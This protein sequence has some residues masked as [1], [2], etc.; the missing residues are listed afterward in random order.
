[1]TGLTAGILS[2][3]TAHADTLENIH[4]TGV[5]RIAVPQD[6]APFGSASSDMSLQGYDVEVAKLTAAALHVKLQLVPVTMAN[7]IPYLVTNKVDLALNLG[8]NPERAK[9]I[10]FTEPYAPY[11]TA[12]FGPQAVSVPDLDALKT[13]K[14]AVVTSSQEDLF[15]TKN[16]P[17][18]TPIFRYQDN[19]SAVAAFLSGQTDFLATGNIVGAKLLADN[20][21]RGFAQKMLLMNS[22]VRAAVRKGDDAM[23]EAVNK[24][25]ASEKASGQL[26][27][28]SRQWLKQPLDAKP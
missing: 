21:Q 13:R 11:Y 27:A 19:S 17:A 3:T 24:V 6:Y 9:V 15:I 23:L 1:M 25:F 16:T 18:G 20:P 5:I 12:V 10:D 8:K 7:K 28:L 14:I 4:K 2:A 26:D 22:P